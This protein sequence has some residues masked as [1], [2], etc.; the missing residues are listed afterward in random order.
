MLKIIKHLYQ[1]KKK[2]KLCIYKIYLI[3]AEGYKNADI[4]ILIIFN[5]KKAGE[6]WPSLKGVGSGMGVQKIYDLVL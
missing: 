2:R 1:K 3:W 4:H 6:I 5:N